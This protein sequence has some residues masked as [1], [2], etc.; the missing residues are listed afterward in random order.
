MRLSEK[1]R[2]AIVGSGNIGTDLMYKL[3]RA[4]IASSL[5]LDDRDRPRL[6]RAAAGRASRGSRRRP[7]GVDWLLAHPEVPEFVFEATSAAAHR[8]NAPR[9]AEA[10]IQAIDLT[11]AAVGPYVVP[12]GQ[13][14]R[15]TSTSPNVNMI[16][17]GGQATIPIVAA[18]AAVTRCRTRR[19]SPRSRRARPGPGRGRTSTSS[20]DDRQAA[21]EEIGGAESRQGDHH[22]QP[23]RAA[24]DHARHRLLR[25]LRRTPTA[26]PIPPRSSAMRDGGRRATCPATGWRRAA[27][28]RAAGRLGRQRPRRG[29]PRGRGRRRLPARLRRQPGH[30]DGRRRSRSARSWRAASARRSRER[31][32]RSRDVRITTRPS[33][34]AAT[35]CGT[36]SP[37]SRCARSRGA[38]DRAGVA[39]IEVSHGDGLGGAS[40]NYGFSLTDELR[41]DRGRR[42]RGASGRGSRSCCCRGSA[43]S[44]TC[45]RRARARRLGHPRSPPTAPRPTSRPRTSASPASSAS[46]PSAS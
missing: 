18:V 24:A 17:C 45:A 33:A 29:L 31:P 12:V 28:R 9:I 23:G 42:R 36:S 38:L 14:P 11:P 2:C 30:H 5:A 37:P 13:P 34:T 15:S 19:S 10:G 44:R 26:T 8:A 22:P 20:P 40:F 27:V 46:R 16:T 41:A 1:V 7:E 32:D 25:D 4:T 3:L 6:R 43:P 39:V 21:L 35:R